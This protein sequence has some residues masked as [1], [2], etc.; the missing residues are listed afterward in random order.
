MGSS[1]FSLSPVWR[2]DVSG[3]W[4]QPRMARAMSTLPA[5]TAG[6]PE[7]LIARGVVGRGWGWGGRRVC[8]GD[9]QRQETER[10]ER[11][12]WGRSGIQPPS[13]HVLS[14]Q[15]PRVQPEQMQKQRGRRSEGCHSLSVCLQRRADDTTRAAS[16]EVR[17]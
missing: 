1:H 11:D 17:G 5:L 16:A 7:L 12:S 9:Q 14:G 3:S 2:R 4:G 6:S 10:G 15:M 13:H 8:R